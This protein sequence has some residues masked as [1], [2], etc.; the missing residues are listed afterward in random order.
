MKQYIIV[1]QKQKKIGKMPVDKS[2]SIFILTTNFQDQLACIKIKN[3]RIA[4]NI[5]FLVFVS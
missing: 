2:C 5:N 1:L 4:F 3:F